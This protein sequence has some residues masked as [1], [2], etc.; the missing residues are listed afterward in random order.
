MLKTGVEEWEVKI[1]V[2]GRTWKRFYSLSKDIIG[3]VP[4]GERIYL[5]VLFGV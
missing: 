4:Y 2:I 3:T 5:D 1:G